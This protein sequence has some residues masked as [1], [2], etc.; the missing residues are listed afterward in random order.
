[1]GIAATQ[2]TFEAEVVERSHEVP[3]VVD[4]WAGWCAPCRMLAP[5]LEESVAGRDGA[6][7]LAKVDVDA[8]PELAR[9]FGVQGIPAVKAFR[10]GQVV[11]EFVGVRSGPQVDAFLDALTE[12]SAA[13]RLVA[14]LRESD[15]HPDV[16]AA[17]DAEDYERAFELLLSELAGAAPDGREEIRRLMVALFED[18]GHD[19][20][21]TA[22]YRRRLATA[23]Y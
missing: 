10:R 7:V 9:R 8:E 18:L 11:S 21:V 16:V 2:Q 4:F 15:D 14:D 22:S 3:V 1:M 12:P 23:L 5:V 13:E 19:H 6:L 20:P 17:L